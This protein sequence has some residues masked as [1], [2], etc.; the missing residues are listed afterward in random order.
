MDR[1]QAMEVFVRVAEAG[2]FTAVADR[3][4]AEAPESF[5]PPLS[6]L[7]ALIQS[8]QISP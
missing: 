6:Q 2:S 7:D 8:I 5:Q 1:L 3:L 4:N